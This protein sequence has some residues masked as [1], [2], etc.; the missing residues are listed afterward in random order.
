MQIFIRLLSG[1]TIS[2]DVTIDTILAD[3][4]QYANEY[5]TGYQYKKI[6]LIEDYSADLN[7]NIEKYKLLEPE[8]SLSSLYKDNIIKEVIFLVL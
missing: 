2:M 7:V 3:I 1:K 6:T 4:I 8:I 5:H